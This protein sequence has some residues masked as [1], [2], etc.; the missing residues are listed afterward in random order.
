MIMPAVWYLFASLIYILI[1]L[2]YFSKKFA[3][4]KIILHSLLYFYIIAVIGVTIFPLPIQRNFIEDG[5]RS[6]HLNH[7]FVP[8]SSILAIW[9]NDSSVIIKQLG[10]NILLGIPLGI[11]LPIIA[12]TAKKSKIFMIGLAFF[13]GI[14]LTQY[15]ISKIL[16]YTYRV[17]DIDDIILNSIGFLIGFGLWKIAIFFRMTKRS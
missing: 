17:A 8:F 2:M 7:N 9:H 3:L 13:A 1:L 5:I 4:K 15:I 16:G 10:G 6:E 12:S 11:L 14:E